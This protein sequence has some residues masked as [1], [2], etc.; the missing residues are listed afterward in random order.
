MKVFH[1]AHGLL[2]EFN[3]V[4]RVMEVKVTPEHLVA[5]LARKHLCPNTHQPTSKSHY[6]GLFTC[7]C[8]WVWACV[9]ISCVHNSMCASRVHVSVRCVCM[10]ACMLTIM[11]NCVIERALPS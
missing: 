2:V 10:R 1:T 5:A 7:T 3:G 9:K 8:G 4:G 6:A 11:S